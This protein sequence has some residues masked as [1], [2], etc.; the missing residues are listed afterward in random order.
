MPSSRGSSQP[1]DGTRISYISC[2][3]RQV[4]Y[5]E[6]HLGSPEQWVASSTVT[7]IS[8]FWLPEKIPVVL[9]HQAGDNL[10]QQPS[11]TDTLGLSPHLLK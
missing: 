3:G 6:R 11:E 1:T 9:S 2:I 7:M 5:H 4:L 8:D 10:L